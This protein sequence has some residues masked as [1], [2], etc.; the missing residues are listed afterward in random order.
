[1][2]RYICVAAIAACILSFTAM[3][4]AQSPHERYIVVLSDDLNL[5][6]FVAADIAQQT[7]GRVGYVYETVLRGFSITMP[8]AARAWVE[9]NPRVAY[10]ES[11]IQV[12]AFAQEIPTGIHRIFATDSGGTLIYGGGSVD[13]DVAVLDSGID[14]NHPDLNVVGGA[15]CLQLTGGGPRLSKYPANPRYNFPVFLA[16]ICSEKGLAFIA[17]GA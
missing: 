16:L 9:R 6:E 14:V 1:M 4:Q 15:N 5:P 2:I 8:P 11:D 3:V 13:V 10:V 17:H 7:G 12:T